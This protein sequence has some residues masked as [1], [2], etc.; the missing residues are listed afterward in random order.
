MLLPSVKA[1]QSLP[2]QTPVMNARPASPAIAQWRLRSYL[3]MPAPRLPLSGPKYPCPHPA[4]PVRI[5]KAV[6][7][8]IISVSN[9]SKTYSS[10]F[11]ALD[12]IHLEIRRGV[13]LALGGRNGGGQ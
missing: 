6:M 3:L 7:S 12:R 8:A 9:L 10:G 13:V 1:A 4:F 11:K 5:I 2:G